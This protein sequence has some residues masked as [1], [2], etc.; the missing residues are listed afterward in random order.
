MSATAQPPLRR[1]TDTLMRLHDLDMLVR[2]YREVAS[3][4]LLEGSGFRISGLEQLEQTRDELARTIDRH[5]LELY[6]K[7]LR[8]YG[9]AVVPVRDRV[10]LGCFMT[11]PSSASRPTEGSDVLL[12]CESCGRILYWL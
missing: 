12:L 10:C 5:W 11:L 7:A 1:N 4:E 3:R 2:D 9:R 8:R 6:E